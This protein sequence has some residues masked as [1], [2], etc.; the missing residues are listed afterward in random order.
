MGVFQT[1]DL[2]P[3]PSSRTFNKK[4][5][6]RKKKH[7]EPLNQGLKIEKKAAQTAIRRLRLKGSIQQRNIVLFIWNLIQSKI[8]QVVTGPR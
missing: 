1:L 3:I 4:N 2:G 6:K 5:K 7:K 8:T